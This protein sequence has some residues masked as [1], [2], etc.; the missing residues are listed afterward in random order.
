MTRA[1]GQHT[2][3]EAECEA[4]QG[5]ISGGSYLIALLGGRRG[6][7]RSCTDGEHGVVALVDVG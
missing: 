7:G 1:Y 6:G 3:E 5:R 4:F 2:S